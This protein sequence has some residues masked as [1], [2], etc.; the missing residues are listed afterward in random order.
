M[1]SPQFLR[2]ERRAN[3]ADGPNEQAD[4]NRIRAIRAMMLTRIG[5]MCQLG[6]LA[7]LENTK[8]NH[9]DERTDE[10]RDHG[11]DVQ[12]AEVEAREFA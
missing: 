11:V 8:D 6:T 1:Q 3:C 7:G 4:R 5:I 12:D 10:L 9:A 2:R